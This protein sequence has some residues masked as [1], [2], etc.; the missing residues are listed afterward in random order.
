[1]T[2]NRRET[3]FLDRRNGPTDGSLILKNASKNRTFEKKNNRESV[4][5]LGRTRDIH[6]MKSLN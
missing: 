4:V 1:M 6:L 3:R 5:K 2:K